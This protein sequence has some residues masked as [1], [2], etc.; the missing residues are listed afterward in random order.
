MRE[1]SGDTG[2]VFRGYSFSMIAP[3]SFVVVSCGEKSC[4]GGG[5]GLMAG[6]SGGTDWVRI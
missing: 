4:G 1:I 2:G 6:M 5:R 3:E